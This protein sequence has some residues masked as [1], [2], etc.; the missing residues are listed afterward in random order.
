MW[1]KIQ[2]I[3]HYI[4]AI[5]WCNCVGLVFSLTLSLFFSPALKC[6]PQEAEPWWN[7]QYESTLS[8]C[9]HAFWSA[10]LLLLLLLLLLFLC[11]LFLLFNQSQAVVSSLSFSSFS[12]SSRS[13][14]C[15]HTNGTQQCQ[16]GRRRRTHHVLTGSI[17][18]VW[19]HLESVLMRHPTHNTRMQI[20][21]VHT[22]VRRLVGEKEREKREHN[23]NI[24]IRHSK[25]VKIFRIPSYGRVNSFYLCLQVFLFPHRVWLI[26]WTLSNVS[27]CRLLE[28][29]ALRT[30]ALSSPSRTLPSWP[31]PLPPP[32][33]RLP[34]SSSVCR[35]CGD[36][37]K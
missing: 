29:P 11:F 1:C 31:H 34:W 8:T 18:G 2:V 20:F 28:Q 15:K 12:S 23:I 21:R 24:C 33:S 26:S 19:N 14:R 27:L 16:Q 4:P 35:G 3:N 10:L 5:S 22:S 17:L 37:V 32:P 13:G 7:L 25:C 30:T 36:R 9:V 6:T